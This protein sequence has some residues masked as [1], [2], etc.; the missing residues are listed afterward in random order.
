MLTLCR[1]K[2]AKLVNKLNGLETAIYNDGER[3]IPGKT[4]DPDELVRHMSAYV[5]FKN[6][7]EQDIRNGEKTDRPVRIVDL[8]CGVG[9][10]CRLLS[11]LA[12]VEIHGVD[13]S[14]ES[15]QYAAIHYAA[16]NVIFKQ[17]DL[18]AFIP[19]MP[20][21]DYALS[22]GV[23]E[24]LTDGLTLLRRVKWER[25]FLFDVPYREPEG[26]NRHHVLVNLSEADLMALENAEI[27]LED[28]AG[29]IHHVGVKCDCPNVLC[30]LRKPQL[31]PLS[32]CFKFP[33]DSWHPSGMRVPSKISP[34]ELPARRE[35][36]L[37]R[38]VAFLRRTLP[39]NA[40]I[41]VRAIWRRLKRVIRGR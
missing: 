15:L 6:V 41:A 33:T 39:E 7:I 4:H 27:F 24:H 31:R 18:S 38:F 13:L 29:R 22:R 26:R 9:Y 28:F 40:Y 35:S 10:G 12:N 17:A 16:P 11:D 25:R 14:A 8:G 2:R 19:Q 34:P 37:V 5:F 20:T 1:E 21:F 23:F 3:L 36:V 30:A 32:D